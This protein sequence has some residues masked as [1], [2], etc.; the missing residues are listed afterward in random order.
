[1]NRAVGIDVER[2]GCLEHITTNAELLEQIEILKKIKVGPAK[3]LS[4]YFDLS[5]IENDFLKMSAKCIRFYRNYLHNKDLID[6]EEGISKV[7]DFMENDVLLEA[8]G[9]AIFV[10]PVSGGAFLLPRQLSQPLKNKILVSE[11]PCLFDKHGHCL[12]PIQ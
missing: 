2:L 5:K 6:F 1:M 7:I 8:K 10:R 4:C 11:R 12:L 9:V 3:F